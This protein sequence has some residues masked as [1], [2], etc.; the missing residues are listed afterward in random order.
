MPRLSDKEVYR[1][2]LFNLFIISLVRRGRRHPMT[3][4]WLA[5]KSLSP[6]DA[7]YLILTSTSKDDVTWLRR[8]ILTIG[9]IGAYFVGAIS[10]ADRLIDV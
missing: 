10:N 2:E 6:S 7:R 1:R 4:R 5:I 8:V 3:R 9:N